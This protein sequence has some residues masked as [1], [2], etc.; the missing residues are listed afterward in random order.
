MR[1][2]QEVAEDR[3][4]LVAAGVAFYGFLALFPALAAIISIWGLFADPAT[5][6]QQIAQLSGVL[7]GSARDLISGAATRIAAGSPTGLGFGVAISLLLTL[8][9]ANKG[10][11]GLVEGISIAYDEDPG[12]RGFFAKNGIAL[13]LTLGGIIMAIIAIGLVVGLPIALGFLG[14]GPTVETLIGLARWPL[15]A[16]FVIVALAAIYRIAPPRDDA[17]WRWV[18]HGAIVA[19]VLWLVASIAFSIYTANFGSFNETY[20]SV[21]AVA[22]LLMWFFISAFIVLLGAEINAETEK[23]TAR[24]TTTGPERP[25][26]KREAVPADTVAD[27]PTMH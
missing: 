8:W 23:Q 19:T 12:K 24:D 9:S 20:G 17:K 3:L 4:S 21:A 5:V 2:K 15:L 13:A 11:K 18:S 14:L 10:M 1:V 27:R 26:G 25:L 7:P 22:I 16:L 6:Q